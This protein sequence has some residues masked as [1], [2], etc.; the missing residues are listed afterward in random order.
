MLFPLGNQAILPDSRSLLA[1]DRIEEDLTKVRAALSKP[2]EDLARR[3]LANSRLRQYHKRDIQGPQPSCV[4]ESID[5][6]D[7]APKFL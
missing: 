5:W 6:P 3:R 2:F 1:F 7:A 4:P